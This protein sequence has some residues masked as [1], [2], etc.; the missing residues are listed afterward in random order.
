MPAAA[1]STGDPI[2][3]AADVEEAPEVRVPPVPAGV[4]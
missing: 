2:A 1:A 3:D 4:V